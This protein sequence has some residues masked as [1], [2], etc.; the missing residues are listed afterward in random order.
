MK[1]ASTLVAMALFAAPCCF[2]AQAPAQASLET[3]A[4]IDAYD[5][6]EQPDLSPLWETSRFEPGA[7]QSETSI[8]RGGRRALAVTVHS[9]DEFE[10]G[11]HGSSDSERAELLEARRLTSRQNVP[12]EF[13][14][15]M[16]FPAD[17]PIVPT[18]LVIAQW[19]QLCPQS[20]DPCSDDSPV[21]AL[22]YI[23]G[24][25]LV[26]QDL[27]AKHVVLFREKG[28]FRSRWLD[29]R[30]RVRFS[31]NADGRVQVWLGARQ[32]VNLAGVTADMET[33]TTGY[34]NPSPFYFK[35]GLYRDVMQTPMT[36]Y[37]DE[38]RKRQLAYDEF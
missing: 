26:T 5:G 14:F 1:F 27:G 35:M 17:F 25:L 13:S 34:A 4:Q 20:A 19:K 15:S 33:P 8:V 6:F 12:Y 38:Y 9:R 31:P 11:L 32:L 18:R 7:V 30:V 16:F 3:T 10:A 21:L 37:I 36:V 22:R 24:E 29:F 23:A 28:E 2:I